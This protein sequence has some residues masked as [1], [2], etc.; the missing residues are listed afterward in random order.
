MQG[1]GRTAR[2][3][4]ILLL[5]LIGALA[6]PAFAAGPA[7]STVEGVVN[8]PAG[9]EE[10]PVRYPGFIEQPIPNPVK[11][12]APF[13]PR[14]EMF[15]YLEEGPAGADAKAL[16]GT[17]VAWVVSGH[18]F[19]PRVLPVVTGTTV[20]ITNTGR[21]TQ[22]LSSPDAPTLLGK[23]PLVPGGAHQATVTGPV[24]AIHVVAQATPHL[25]GRVVPLPTRYFGVIARD[26]T[27]K[28]E[29]VPVGEWKA[30]V[31]YRDGWLGKTYP[32]T[33][34]GRTDKLTI[35]LPEQLDSKPAA[36]AAAPAPAPAADAK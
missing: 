7:V 35:D 25:E 22:I 28:I 2:A 34:K 12:L 30:R 8:V 9:I 15:V 33:V 31:W 36:P 26:G 21:G 4:A 20:E 29:G 17:T 5:L 14:P 6:G 32:V 24:V 3:V 27:F 11:A 19:A 10:P 1:P 13:D 23:E 16:P 18:T